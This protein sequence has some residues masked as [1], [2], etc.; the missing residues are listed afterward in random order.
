MRSID[1]NGWKQDSY[2]GI[3]T[4]NFIY[5]IIEFNVLSEIDTIFL[6]KC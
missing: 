2:E 3:V 1:K 6:K 5:Y 4:Q